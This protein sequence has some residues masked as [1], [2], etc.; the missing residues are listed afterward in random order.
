MLVVVDKPREKPLYLISMS[1]TIQVTRLMQAWNQRHWI[2]QMFRILK[3]LLAAEACQARTEDAYY[4]HFVLRLMAGFVLFFTTRGVCKGDVTMR[5]IGF[6]LK[7]QW[8]TGGY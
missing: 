6:P 2:E 1:L 3:H 7:H 4:G 5:G 8:M